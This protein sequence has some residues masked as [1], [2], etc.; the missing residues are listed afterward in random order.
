MN[1][2]PETTP[3]QHTSD[4]PGNSDTAPVG[5]TD[6]EAR[7][8]GSSRVID[9]LTK[10]KKALEDQLVALTSENEQLKTQLTMKDTEKTV[11]VGERDKQLQAMIEAKTTTDSELADLRSLKMKVEVAR[12]LNDPGLLSIFE[13]IPSVSDKDAMKALM[14]NISSWGDERVKARE[15]ELLAGVTAPVAQAAPEMALPTTVE[16][17]QKYINEAEYGTEEKAK[18]LNAFRD[19][20]LASTK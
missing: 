9:Q 12:E 4:Q 16:G 14:Q 19:W 13:S 10:D 1:D 20:G 11:A 6:W 2:D 5:G 17:W 18:R 8:K 3:G 7:Y 15:K